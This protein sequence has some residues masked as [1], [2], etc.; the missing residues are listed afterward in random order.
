MKV[1]CVCVSNV[2]G[3]ELEWVAGISLS[4]F[5]I[6]ILRC[7]HYVLVIAR[8]RVQYEKYFSSSFCFHNISRAKG[9]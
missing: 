2:R 4:N 8:C 9:E 7:S 6:P 3:K 5:F 1:L